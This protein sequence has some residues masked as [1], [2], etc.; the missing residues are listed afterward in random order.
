M[1]RVRFIVTVCALACATPAGAS[2]IRNGGFEEGAFGD[3]SVRQILPGDSALP[4]WTV[5]GDSL[6]WYKSAFDLNG[7]ALSPHGGDLAID[8]CDGSVRTCDGSVR[9]VSAAIPTAPG[10]RYRVSYWVGNYA[11][12][13]GPAAVSVQITDGT[14]STIILSETGTARP[15]DLPSTWEQF[16]FDFI[17]DGTS[18]TVILGEVV[19]RYYAGGPGPTYTGLDDV[20]VVAVLD[21]GFDGARLRRPGNARRL[22]ASA[23]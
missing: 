14:S 8:L 2:I 7:Y 4:G 17:A 22:E 3:G 16:A 20:S 6:A 23:G 15:T 11:A 9:I 1:K 10:Q 21:L 5:A 12:N 19:D 13:G 18:S